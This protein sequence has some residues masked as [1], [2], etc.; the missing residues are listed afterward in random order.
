MSII[1]LQKNNARVTINKLI[2]IHRQTIKDI[3]EGK[4]FWRDGGDASATIKKACEREISQCTIMLDALEHMSAGNI[5]RA[6][7]LCKQIMEHIPNDN[8]KN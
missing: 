6:A 7:D 3:D 4:K 5:K 8:R 2:E 1:Q